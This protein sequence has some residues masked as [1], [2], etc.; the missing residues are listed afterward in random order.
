MLYKKLWIVSG[1]VLLA[2]AVGATAVAQDKL[3]KG[4]KK[5]MEKEVLAI[6]TMREIETFKTIDKDDRKLFKEL[7]W[8]RRDPSPNTPNNEFKEIYE[9]RIRQAD[10]MFQ[11]R[12][13]KGFE[14][15]MGQIV[16]LMG[17]PAQR[18]R[19]ERR[20]GGRGFDA[21]GGGA[22]GGAGGD[23]RGPG[24][25]VGADPRGGGGFGR[26]AGGGGGSMV[27]IYDPNP[28]FGF[29]DGLSIEFRQRAQFGFRIVETDELKEILDR[30]KTRLV[31]NPSINYA[32]NEEG[33]LRKLD[34]LYDPNSPAKLILQALRDTQTETTDIGFESHFAHF[35]SNTAETYIPSLME[36]DA[37]QLTWKGDEA[38]TTVFYV[39]EDVDGFPLTQNEENYSPTRVG[40][41]A[42]LEF[43]IQLAAGQYTVYM[44]I[45]D[46]ATEKVGTKIIDLEVPSFGD[47]ELKLST[48][49]VFSE[50]K[51]LE[52]FVPRT[53]QAFLVGGFHFSPKLGRI[54]KK[55]DNLQAVF[56]IYGYGLVGGQPNITMQFALKKDGKMLGRTQALPPQTAVDE[57]V[58]GVM[59]IPLATFEPGNYIVDIMIKD[60]VKNASITESFDFVLEGD[61]TTN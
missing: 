15:D 19:G 24:G 32:R 6:I 3:S 61:G 11:Q 25:G 27:W 10:Q 44:G 8:A 13:M 1:C 4:D 37:S 28:Q 12:G 5:W 14:T 55:T 50:G 31:A 46:N 40:D 26:G 38:D 39:I 23:D 49:V 52:E 7:F 53:G 2:L 29:P 60:N 59:D 16:L 41:K 51:K 43:P 30:V 22:G 35:R 56:N 9:A 42:A 18:Q 54:Y 21:S 34:D 33:R 58:I 20:G 17:Q 48:P 57:I 36:M 47:E 45:R